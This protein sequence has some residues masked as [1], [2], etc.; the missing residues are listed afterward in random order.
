MNIYLFLALLVLYGLPFVLTVAM[1]RR[2]ALTISAL[3]LGLLL[4]ALIALFMEDSRHPVGRSAFG[5]AVIF[6][7]LALASL[8]FGAGITT[9][10]ALLSK[11]ASL[12]GRRGRAVIVLAGFTFLPVVVLIWMS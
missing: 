9:R 5:F 3:L 8:G 10:L 4:L 1:P 2:L 11:R 7:V 6:C 12:Y